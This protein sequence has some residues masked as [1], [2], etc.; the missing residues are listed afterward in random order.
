MSR[1]S[2]IEAKL[3]ALADYLGVEIV[4]KDNKSMCV[5][6]ENFRG[7]L[8]EADA[9]K[10]VEVL[11]DT[12]KFR[13]LFNQRIKWLEDICQMRIAKEIGFAAEDKARLYAISEIMKANYHEKIRK[14]KEDES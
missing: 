14:I 9:E 11:F 8:S 12:E 7:L 5:K 4:A 10:I 6:D 1:K 3:N 13:E 2:D